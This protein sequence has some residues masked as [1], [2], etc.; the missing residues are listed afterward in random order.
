MA[1]PICRGTRVVECPRCKDKS[2]LN[3][4]NVLWSASKC[5]HCKDTG[6]VQLQLID[7]RRPL[8]LPRALS[9]HREGRAR[10]QLPSCKEI[11]PVLAGRERTAVLVAPAERM[12]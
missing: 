1:C 10:Y 2:R 7:S 6:K 5:P 3:D 11:N 9:F 8:N 12:T 4:G